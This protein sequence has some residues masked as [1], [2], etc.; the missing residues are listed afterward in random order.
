[1][2]K[3]VVV[4]EEARHEDLRVQVTLTVQHSVTVTLDGNSGQTMEELKQSALD[5]FH[6]DPI[7][8][9][10]RRTEDKWRAQFNNRSNISV[11]A[12]LV[13]IAAVNTKPRHDRSGW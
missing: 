2:S 7:N 13:S 1:M 11:G 4:A 10:E 3:P 5:E 6:R 12:E 9:Y 8:R